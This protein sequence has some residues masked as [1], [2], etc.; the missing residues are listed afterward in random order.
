MTP[1][2]LRAF[3]AVARHRGFSAAARALG[4]SQPTLT[5]QVQSL[6]REHNVELFFRR[7]RRVDLSETAQR[8]LPIAQNI[9]ELELDALNLLVN[10][11]ALHVGHLRIGAVGPFHVIEMVDAYRAR[12]PR[13]EL[14]I[15]LGNSAQTLADLENYVTDVAV[16][17]SFTDDARFHALPYADHAVV[18]FAHRSHP[19][20]QRDSVTLAELDQQP[21]LMREQG[22]TTR[23]ALEKALQQAGVKVQVVMEI[24]SREALRE[25][26]ARGLGLGAV[27]EAEFVPDERFR[28]VRIEGDPVSTHT[29]V[30]CLAERREGRLVG[31]FMK[32]AA[33]S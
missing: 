3:L 27:S 23:L 4:V 25:A 7:G 22:S 9:A 13:V 14:S 21:M 15:R 18:L 29:Y 6:E 32:I 10:S 17:A 20:Y 24:G 8:L 5:T 33:R 16:L 2:Q 12:Y 11:G 1:S 31:S 30:Y 26:V 19:F 28:M